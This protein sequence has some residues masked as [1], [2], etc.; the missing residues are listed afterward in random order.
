MRKEKNYK[1]ISAN[2]ADDSYLNLPCITA[3]RK[4]CKIGNRSYGAQILAIACRLDNLQKREAIKIGRE[5][6]SKCEK[7]KENPFRWFE[8]LNWINWAYRQDK[9][10]WNCKLPQQ[11]EKCNK[12]VCPFYLVP[13]KI[14]HL[15]REKN[16]L[17]LLDLLITLRTLDKEKRYL[18]MVIR[19]LGKIGNNTALDILKETFR[20]SEDF[21]IKEEIINS[22]SN[23]GGIEAERILRE[24]LNYINEPSFKNKVE[25]SIIK[26]RGRLIGDSYQKLC[27]LERRIT[28]IIDELENDEINREKKQKLKKLKKEIKEFIIFLETQLKISESDELLIKAYRLKTRIEDVLLMSSKKSF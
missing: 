11:I 12:E 15:Q 8:V 4:G 22:I 6:F 3:I 7:S 26:V 25:K 17:S 2:F 28:K 20:I 16:V 18:K 23:I 14:K 27:G 9:I 21:K 19:A 13:E 10:Y 24:I 5:Y 1:K